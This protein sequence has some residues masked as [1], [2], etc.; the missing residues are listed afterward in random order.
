VRQKPPSARMRELLVRVARGEVLRKHVGGT[1][2]MDGRHVHE[3]TVQ[4]LLGRGLLRTEYRFPTSRVHITDEG[5][6]VAAESLVREENR[7]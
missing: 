2:F 5:W 1:Y 3:W 4:G 7:S 6:L